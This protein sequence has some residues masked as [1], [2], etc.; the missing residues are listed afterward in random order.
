MATIR[1]DSIRHALTDL[2]ALVASSDDDTNAVSGTID[3]P[4]SILETGLA[5]ASDGSRLIGVY[6]ARRIWHTGERRVYPLS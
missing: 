2:R 3:L 1:T 4:D 5:K 6:E